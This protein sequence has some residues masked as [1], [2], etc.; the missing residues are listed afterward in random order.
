MRVS[1]KFCG[2]ASVGKRSFKPVEDLNGDA[3]RVSLRLPTSALTFV[4]L[5]KIVLVVT[6]VVRPLFIVYLDVFFMDGVQSV[7]P[8]YTCALRTPS[9][10]TIFSPC[11]RRE[12]SHPFMSHVPMISCINACQHAFQD[13]ECAE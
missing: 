7:P 11:V 5:L 3:T 4:L 8:L 6:A 12:N 13:S 2:W 10:N 1:K 9:R